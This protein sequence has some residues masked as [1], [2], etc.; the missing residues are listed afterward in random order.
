MAIWFD[1]AL[2]TCVDI[3]GT[4]LVLDKP[5]INPAIDNLVNSPFVLPLS[6]SVLFTQTL[7]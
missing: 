1:S 5:K 2:T 6:I 4:R 3:K 7:P